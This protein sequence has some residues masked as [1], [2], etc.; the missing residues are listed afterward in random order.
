M[1]RI[2]D[3]AER[4]RRLEE[5]QTIAGLL[6]AMAPSLAPY[7]FPNGHR[8]GI[9][10]RTGDLADSK[11]QSLVVNVSG[12]NPGHWHDFNPGMAQGKGDMLDLVALVRFGGDKR[13]A[14][15]WARSYLG[16]DNLDPDRLATRRAEVQRAAARTRIDAAKQ[17]EKRRRAALALFTDRRATSIVDTPV[18]QYLTGRGID[19]SCLEVR[20]QQYAPGALKWH[21]AVP[22]GQ[23]AMEGQEAPR[24]PAMIARILSSAGE[25]EGRQVATHRTWLAQRAD[26]SWGKADMPDPKSTLGVYRDVG[27]YIPVWKGAHRVTLRDLPGDVDIFM[28]EGIE[29]ALSAACARPELR[30]LAAVSLSNIANIIIPPRTTGRLVILKQNDPP[31]SPAAEQLRLAIEAQQARGV[32]VAVVE[33]PEGVKDPND[34]IRMEAA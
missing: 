4:R 13:S 18:E 34:L 19:L 14:I 24:L 30:V 11:G 2:R 32:T 6:N 16:M 21:P 22:C 7:L 15:A 9:H 17:A 31:G 26:G 33:M 1:S 25:Q 12:G 29:D 3:E 27:G 28:S 10:W 23:L 5:I 20:G 8:S